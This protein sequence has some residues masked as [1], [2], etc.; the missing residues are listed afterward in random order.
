MGPGEKKTWI[1]MRPLKA[2]IGQLESTLYDMQQLFLFYY[3]DKLRT[4][5][6]S[7]FELFIVHSNPYQQIKDI[8][9]GEKTPSKRW[10]FAGLKVLN[11]GRATEVVLETGAT[12]LYPREVIKPL[13]Y[14][15]SHINDYQKSV[16]KS[17]SM[18]KENTIFGEEE[19][20]LQSKK[21]GRK[22]DPWNPYAYEIIV[23][24]DGSKEA[25]EDS[26]D[27]WCE[28]QGII[29]P[30]KGNRSAFKKAMKRAEERD[31]KN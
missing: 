1:I 9:D 7:I 16:N 2:V 17:T 5:S 18:G 15:V 24:G 10:G 29:D 27:Y 31:K 19:I 8:F 6:S 25:W 21:P 13:D 20:R 26:F 23:N 4:E 14:F 30:D 3:E 22:V 28:M 11:L 12:F